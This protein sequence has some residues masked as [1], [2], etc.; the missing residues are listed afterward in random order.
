MNKTSKSCIISLIWGITGIFAYAHKLASSVNLYRFTHFLDFLIRV[1]LRKLLVG[2]ASPIPFERYL[3]Y[4]LH[5]FQSFCKKQ[6]F[7]FLSL[8]KKVMNVATSS[9]AHP[10]SVKSLQ[11]S[12]SCLQ[13]TGAWHAP[14]ISPKEKLSIGSSAELHAHPDNAD[15]LLLVLPV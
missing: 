3:R 10:L 14:V 4:R 15:G 13:L 5:D 9:G 11:S 8:Q 12:L 1:N 7:S 6:N 2:E